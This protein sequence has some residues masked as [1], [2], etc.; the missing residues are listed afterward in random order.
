MSAGVSN[1]TTVNPTQVDPTW[2]RMT[3]FGVVNFMSLTNARVEFD[4]S[5]I[6]NLCGYNDSGKSALLTA[7]SILFYDRHSNDQVNFIQDEQDYFEVY[8]EFASGVRISKTKFRN[9]KSWWQ[10]EKDGK[11]LYTNRTSSGVITA[12]PGVPEEISKYLNV[13]SDDATNEYLN[14]RDTNSRLFLVATSGGENY[15]ILNAILR[16]DVLAMAEQRI[17]EDR[18]K[19]QNELAELILSNN[20]RVAEANKI[21]VLPDDWF[22]VLSK[23]KENLESSKLRLTILGDLHAKKQI[24][25]DLVVPDELQ[26]IDL[27]RY[28]DLERLHSLKG[29]LDE[30]L[31]EELSEI[32]LDRL[33]A[34]T[35]LR[36][37]QGVLAEP[38]LPELSVIDLERLSMLESLRTLEQ[39]QLSDEDIPPELSTLDVSRLHDLERLLEQHRQVQALDQELHQVEADFAEVSGQLA[40]LSQLHGFKICPNCGTIAV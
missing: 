31:P 1:G 3:A 35:T 28:E 11:V 21:Q 27:S 30:S 14:Y 18:N 4:D 37:L 33:Q 7:L 19:K 15:K 9:G 20:T 26:L 16:C 22:V 5:N 39:E 17:R 34:L 10:M 2:D 8:A 36:D 32:S 24:I 29:V 40:E 13:V 6:I 25:D 12:M 38:D 23:R